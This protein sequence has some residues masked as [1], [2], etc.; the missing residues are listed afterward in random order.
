MYSEGQF[1]RLS[2]QYITSFMKKKK[3]KLDFSYTGVVSC[4]SFMQSRFEMYC[5]ILAADVCELH[6]ENNTCP[7][8]CTA[9][10]SNTACSMR[11]P[12]HKLHFSNQGVIVHIKD[13]SR[14]SV[15]NL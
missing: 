11:F 1:V 2:N 3:K 15:Y 10:I 14:Y 4:Y 8:S 12:V 9:D 13:S 6:N 5:I 7:F